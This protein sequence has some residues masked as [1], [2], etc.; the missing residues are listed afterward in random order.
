VINLHFYEDENNV[1]SFDL[2]EMKLWTLVNALLV[3]N[4]TALLVG[5]PLLRQRNN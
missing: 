1:I 5:K 3:D 4:F 2:L